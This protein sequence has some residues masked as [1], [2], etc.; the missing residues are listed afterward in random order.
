M[1]ANDYPKYCEVCKKQINKHDSH[2]AGIPGVGVLCNPCH[3][4]W[5]A[6]RD[7]IIKKEAGSD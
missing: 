1:S 3:V 6:A 7:E 5:A 4:E 2:Y